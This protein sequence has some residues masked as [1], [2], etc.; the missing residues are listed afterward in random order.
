MQA[1]ELVCLDT[2][3]V[4]CHGYYADFSRSF[5]CGREN[6]TARQRELYRLAWEQVQENIAR[7][8]PGT[9]FR[10]YSEGA[11]KVPSPHLPY[12]YYLLAHGVGMTGEYPYILH[13]LDYRRHGYDGEIEPGMTLCV[14][15][16]IGDPGSGQGVKLEEQVLVTE[17]GALALSRYPYD[18]RLLGREL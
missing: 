11:W 5:L 16:Y 7:I 1:G 4:G 6:P 9:G 3:V 18:E 10:E 12:R 14:E 8:R 2:D 13:E 17:S 15:S